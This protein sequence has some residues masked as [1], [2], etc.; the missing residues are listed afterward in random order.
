MHLAIC[1]PLD[2]ENLRQ[3]LGLRLAGAPPGIGGLPVDIEIVEMCQR[4]M[5]L[6]VVTGDMSLKEPFR[7]SEGPLRLRYVPVRPRARDR[8][9]GLFQQ[10]IRSMA[11]ELVDARPDVVHAHWSYEFALAGLRADLPLIVTCHDSPWDILFQHRDAYRMIRLLM[12]ISVFRRGRVFTA[13][14]P[15]VKDRIA[16]M[17]RGECR[18]IANGMDLSN[19]SPRSPTV[20]RRSGPIL[21]ALGNSSRRKN[22]GAA[23]RAFPLIRRELPGAE[24][25][26]FGPGLTDAENCVEGIW[27]HGQQSHPDVIAFLN[28]RADLMIHPSYEDACPM[29]VLEGQAAGLPVVGGIG[30]GGVPYILGASANDS[31]VDVRDPT[32]IAGASIRIFKDKDMYR[33]LSSQAKEN[34]QQRFTAQMM[35]DNYLSLIDDVLNRRCHRTRPIRFG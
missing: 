24:L 23:L 1:G 22:I 19:F 25:H 7:I 9:L 11:E 13:V 29:A 6:T 34:I 26:L 32:A 20:A 14:S 17:L 35:V 28:E 4:G 21:V 18:V 33:R 12:A 15:Y 16:W 30:S 2:T 8:A 10:E 3:R 5:E 31:L 27:F